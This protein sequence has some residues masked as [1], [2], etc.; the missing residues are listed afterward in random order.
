M[1]PIRVDKSVPSP[2]V[3]PLT[4]RPFEEPVLAADGWTY[5]RRALTGWFAQHGGHSPKTRRP[6]PEAVVPNTTLARAQRE[7]EDERHG[8]IP[9][10][11]QGE[12]HR[13]VECPVTLEPMQHPV[14]LSDGHDYDFDSA[15]ALVRQRGRSPLTEE[16][17]DAVEVLRPNKALQ[18]LAREVQRRD[19]ASMPPPDRKSLIAGGF[20][21]HNLELTT[22]H[23]RPDYIGAA[24][25]ELAQQTDAFIDAI[26]HN[27]VWNQP[28]P[29]SGWLPYRVQERLAESAEHFTDMA[30]TLLARETRSGGWPH[31]LERALPSIGESITTTQKVWKDLTESYSQ[32]KCLTALM[33]GADLEEQNV[34]FFSEAA[35][36]V[37]SRGFEYDIVT[38]LARSGMACTI[39]GTACLM[40][41]QLVPTL[42]EYTLWLLPVVVV[43]TPVAS[44]GLM[45]FVKGVQSDEPAQTNA[46]TGLRG[47]DT[48]RSRVAKMPQPVTRGLSYGLDAAYYA[49]FVFNLSNSARVY[50]SWFVPN[51]DLNSSLWTYGAAAAGAMLGAGMHAAFGSS[52]IM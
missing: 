1:S 39:A 43:V 25:P 11:L 40:M 38:Q 12:W 24:S 9:A 18:Q 5:E 33:E 10:F 22:R 50:T 6:M 26:I 19:A 30:H 35:H 51:A 44:K 2:F 21:V 15:K 7:F 45:H 29:A 8:R 4:K 17:F 34:Q 42:G 47:A 41:P 32:L 23:L 13:T 3:C 28:V 49:A 48:L 20:P 31:M 52:M 14:R 37:A 16:V 36:F 46:F 27:R